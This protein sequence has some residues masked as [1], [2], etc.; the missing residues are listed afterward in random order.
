MMGHGGRMM[1]GFAEETYISAVH[2]SLLWVG[3]GMV[4]L[5]VAISYVVIKA[6]TRPLST[7]TEAVR[8]I[9]R[10]D[11]GKTVPIE[12]RDEV[13]LLSETFNDMSRQLQKMIICAVNFLPISLMSY[14]HRL[15]FCKVIWKE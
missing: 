2:Q 9:G 6:M 13:G 12:R 14:G 7:L 10:G 1:H 5:S 3:L 8:S 4:V 11:Y 15:L